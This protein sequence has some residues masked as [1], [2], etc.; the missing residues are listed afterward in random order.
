M[1]AILLI[2]QTITI[3]RIC[4]TTIFLNR[5]IDWIAYYNSV[6]LLVMNVWAGYQ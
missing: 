4:S 3:M 5:C 2:M 1:H 6:E